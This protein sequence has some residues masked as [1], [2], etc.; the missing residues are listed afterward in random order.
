LHVRKFENFS[1]G[2]RLSNLNAPAD[3]D[4]QEETMLLLF[5]G[6]PKLVQGK[7]SGRAIHPVTTMHDEFPVLREFVAEHLQK[8]IGESVFPIPI[9]VDHGMP[10]DFTKNRI[11]ELKWNPEAMEVEYFGDVEDSVAK[12]IKNGLYKN[13]VSIEIGFPPG[14]GIDFVNGSTAIARAVP[15]GFQYKAVSLLRRM[16]PSDPTTTL[17]VWNN[18]VEALRPQ[19][20]EG[21]R[22]KENDGMAKLTDV[23]LGGLQTF[24]E[25]GKQLK[26]QGMTKDEILEKIAELE[27]QNQEIM[28]QLYPEAELTEEQRNELNVKS[29]QLWNEISAYREALAALTVEEVLDVVKPEPAKENPAEPETVNEGAEPETEEEPEDDSPS[30]PEK[31]EAPETDDEESPTPEKKN[32]V[33]EAILGTVDSLQ[34]S[35]VVPVEKLES[36]LPSLQ[37]ERSMS[38]GAQ[39]FV[40]QVKGLVREAKEVPQNG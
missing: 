5:G 40:Q 37:A 38:Y 12:D 11:T 3:A 18:A 23:Q 31:P 1:G 32:V 35:F 30:E 19:N 13:G 22:V 29:E 16:T 28:D 26:Q 27:R 33:G 14:S 2:N 36:M 20:Q 9:N 24:R 15:K 4:A 21:D 8:A 39:R 25:Y 10:L 34:P 6:E 17:K 7:I